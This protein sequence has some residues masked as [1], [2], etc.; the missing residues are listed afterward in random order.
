MEDTSMNE[1]NYL[2]ISAV[3]F[4]LMATTHLVRLFS[5]FSIV[6]GPWTVP[7]WGS[8]LGVA[9]GITLSVWAF[10]LAYRLQFELPVT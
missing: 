6:V 7:I 1:R 2:L 4:G 3:I 10:R 9:V 8:L 5:P